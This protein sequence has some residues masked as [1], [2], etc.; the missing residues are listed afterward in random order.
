[1][2]PGLNQST[3]QSLATILNLASLEKGRQM[4]NKLD[5]KQRSSTLIL[6]PEFGAVD[7]DGYAALTRANAFIDTLGTV[8]DLI[9]WLKDNDLHGKDTLKFRRQMTEFIPRR[10]PFTHVFQS[11]YGHG[12]NL[13]LDRI[14]QFRRD[15]WLAE[16]HI[17]A[18]LHTIEG[19]H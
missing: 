8:R 19:K 1:M 5:E 14:V 13:A 4:L 9:K 3:I 2:M 6:I 18:I 17:D 15:V 12:S 7:N 10:N 16:D 11:F